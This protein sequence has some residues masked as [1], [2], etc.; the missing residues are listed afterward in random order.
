[1]KKAIWYMN[2]YVELSENNSC[3]GCFG[4]SMGDCENCPM[5][6]GVSNE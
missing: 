1:M 5:K 2:K 3:D 4:A 6:E